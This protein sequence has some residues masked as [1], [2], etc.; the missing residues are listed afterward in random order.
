MSESLERD[1]QLFFNYTPNDWVN[2]HF[3]SCMFIPQGK[4]DF[5]MSQRVTTSRWRINNIS[6]ICACFIVLQVFSRTLP[7]QEPWEFSA[8]ILL[9]LQMKQ[10]RLQ[11]I[12]DFPSITRPA[13]GWIMSKIPASESQSCM[14]IAPITTKYQSQKYIRWFSTILELKKTSEHENDN[15]W[16]MQRNN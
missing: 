1:P 10:W 8:F 5:T 4:E 6:N 9:I 12:S 15:W 11:S 16:K 14:C 2:R 3:L 13:K 7:S